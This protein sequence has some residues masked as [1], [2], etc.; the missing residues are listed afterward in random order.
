MRPKVAI[1]LGSK[2]DLAT[3]GEAQEL[4]SAL[5]VEAEVHI[6]SAHRSP[7]KATAFAREAQARGIEAII[8]GAG[9][10]AHL[11]GVLAAHTIVPVIGVPVAASPLQGWDA[12]LS[13]VQMPK[14]VPVATMALGAAG[15]INAAI[16][17]A[18][19]LAGKYPALRERLCRLKAVMEERVSFSL[20]EILVA[21]Q[22][23][24]PDNNF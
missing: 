1:V 21:L 2:S 7:Q 15:A 20:P 22:N 13:I 17:A 14:G 18:Q 6:L 3:F 24:Q 8:A 23:D 19:L 10:A 9:G 5:G 4:L 11:P 16:F 12:L